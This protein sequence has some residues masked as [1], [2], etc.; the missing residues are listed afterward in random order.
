M[1]AIERHLHE[2]DFIEREMGRTKSWKRK[3]DLERC[4]N[5]LQKEL[6]IYVSLKAKKN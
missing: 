3:K 6:R 2:I 4:R 5:R 1:K